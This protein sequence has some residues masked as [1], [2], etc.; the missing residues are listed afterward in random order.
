[1]STFWDLLLNLGQKNKTLNDNERQQ[2]IKKHSFF[3]I[4]SPFSIFYYHFSRVK[5]DNLSD[6]V[7]YRFLLHFK[8]VKSIVGC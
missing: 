7:I 3:V 1:M 8:Y 4:Q 6:F 5:C 2:R